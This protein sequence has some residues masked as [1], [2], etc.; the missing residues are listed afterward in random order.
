MASGR[1][2]LK[3]T[4]EHLAFV[5]LSLSLSP[6]PLSFSLSLSLS[7][8]LLS[9]F[10][11]SSLSLLS[12]LFSFSSLSL[13]LSL[14]LLSLFSLSSLSLLSLSSLS[15]LSLFSLS[16]LSLSLLSPLSLSRRDSWWMLMIFVDYTIFCH[17]LL[18][19]SRQTLGFP[20]ASIAKLVD[21][22]WCADRQQ[23]RHV[24]QGHECP[25]SCQN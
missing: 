1:K 11:L 15:L 21:T 16:S 20:H 8:S 12:L 23:P 2:P 7:L 3:N 5:D 25:S 10:S 19:L 22:S 17:F 4:H 9:L 18:T 6:S 14:S 13:S 24:C